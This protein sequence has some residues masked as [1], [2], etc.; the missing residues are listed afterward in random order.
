MRNPK[1]IARNTLVVLI[2]LNALYAAFF[3]EEEYQTATIQTTIE[4]DVPATVWYVYKNDFSEERQFSDR[5]TL[6]PGLEKELSFQI[7]SS[8]QELEYIGLFWVAEKNGSITLKSY[9]FQINDEFYQGK[10]NRQYIDYVS[11]GS[12]ISASEEGITVTTIKGDRNWIMLDGTDGINTARDKKV[13]NFMPLWANGILLVLLLGLQFFKSLKFAEIRFK[14]REFKTWRIILF[15]LWALLMPFWITIGHF[16]LATIVFIT[17]LEILI[18][19]DIGTLV[20]G[21]KPF[22]SALLLFGWIVLSSFVSSE[23]Q[24]VAD[25]AFDL[26]YLLLVPIALVGLDS[27]DKSSIY[28]IFEIAVWTYLLLMLIY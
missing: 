15:V 11:K 2:I 8:D 17:L 5:E 26:S 24:Q 18:K 16:I 3:F 6:E 9:G 4:T 12:F 13:S 1:T 7:E 21:L 22:W 28:K 27:K 10:G 25:T 14:I 23:I 19:K 20:T